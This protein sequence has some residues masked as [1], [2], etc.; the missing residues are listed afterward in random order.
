VRII[1]TGASGQV[2]RELVALGAEPLTRRDLDLQDV[3]ADAGAFAAAARR[4]FGGADA[5]IHTAAFTG[6][7]A[8]EDPANAPAVRA[9]NAVA[10]GL[11]ATAARSVGAR[12]VHVST[13]YV[14]SGVPAGDDGPTSRPWR[15]DDPVSPVNVYGATKE[16]GERGVLAAGGAVVRTSWVWS[17]P[18]APG[19]DF[20]TTMAGLAERGVD[21]R[22]VDDQSGRPTFAPDL[23]AGLW[24]LAGRPASGIL[25]FTNS[26]EPVTWCGLARAV[27]AGL[28][29]DPERVR[30]CT[31]AEY[32]T[33]A[34]RPEWSVL[35]L[36]PWR[37][38][39][40]EP[41]E[42]RDALVRGLR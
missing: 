29:H 7:D 38:A 23:A 28:G 12:F 18:S 15:V 35:D 26:G 2:G 25:N 9:V 41:P 3:T 8:A 11:L 40:G 10:P 37:A 13:D 19:K 5:V 14:F 21:P 32:P 33:P 36:A 24:R 4:L 30:P 20:V 34:P 27:F 22:V 6:V 42:W 16:E 31:T 39:V 1:A 17:G